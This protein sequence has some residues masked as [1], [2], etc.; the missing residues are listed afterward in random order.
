MRT[1]GLITFMIPAGFSVACKMFTGN[2]IGDGKADQAKTYYRVNLLIAVS[3]TTLTIAFLYF[4]R[5]M[6]I[7]IYTEQ[8]VIMDIMTNVWPIL[9]IFVFLDTTQE[10]GSSVIRGTG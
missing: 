9:L 4:K 1:L 10:M 8:D 6:I 7:Q 5:D 3:F 2:S